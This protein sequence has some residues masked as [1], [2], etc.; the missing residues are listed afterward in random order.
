M[1]GEKERDDNLVNVRTRDNVVSF[2]S[3]DLSIYPSLESS[4]QV[5][6]VQTVLLSRSGIFLTSP[7][8]LLTVAGLATK[9]CK[10][11]TGKYCR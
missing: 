2:Q 3:L 4:L 10:E 7:C 1:V 5:V 8:Q 6:L 9:S 11:N